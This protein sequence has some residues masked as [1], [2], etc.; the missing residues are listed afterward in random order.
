MSWGQSPS[1]LT[2]GSNFELPDGDKRKIDKE[3][4]YQ[5]LDAENICYLRHHL[6]PICEGIYGV[7]NGLFTMMIASITY[8]LLK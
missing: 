6:C 5:I 1:L 2:G 4:V 3:R 8:E 7:E